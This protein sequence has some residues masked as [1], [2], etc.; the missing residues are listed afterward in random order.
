[1]SAHSVSLVLVTRKSRRAEPLSPEE[2]RRSIIKAVTPL[3]IEHGTS[4]TT[5]QMAKAA[6]IAEGTIFGVFT[7][8]RALI[9]ESVK[10]SMDPE[11]TQRALAEIYPGAPI[12]VKMAEAARILT[13]R[14]DRVITLVSILRTLPP[15]TTHDHR[16]PDFVEQS[17][18]AIN[19]SL[20]KMFAAHGDRLRIEPDKA[21]AAF[22]S[23]ILSSRHPA[24]AGKERLSVPEIVAVLTNGI[25][26]PDPVMVA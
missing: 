18:A 16:P 8:K 9:F 22:R 12:E 19:D 13:E 24:L 10:F 20:T 23:M 6:G 15:P 4:V 7:D 1:V 21:A 25:L 26:L 3:L 14:Y 5:K 17:N 11:P 2:R